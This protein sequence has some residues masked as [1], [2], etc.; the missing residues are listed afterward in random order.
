MRITWLGFALAALLVA[1]WPAPALALGPGNVAVSDAAA[2]ALIGVD[3]KT[4][5]RKRI[6]S[7]TIGSGEDFLTPVGLAVE[8]SGSIL[9]IDSGSNALYRVD[10]ASGDRTVV[11]DPGRGAGPALQNPHN[12]GVEAS[13]SALVFD[14]GIPALLRV[15]ADTGDRSLLSSS[16]AGDGTCFGEVWG[17]V[18]LPQ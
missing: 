2:N 3:A 4:G 16:K 12:V 1:A 17:L 5:E 10:P 6:S 15:D 11:S 8:K 14:D 9:V 18:I 13:G 7:K